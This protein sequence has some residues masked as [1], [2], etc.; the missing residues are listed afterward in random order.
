VISSGKARP[1]LS[2][3]VADADEIETALR[4]S[5]AHL[6]AL[7]AH[8]VDYAI[9]GLDADGTVSSWNSGAERL[10]G[11]IPQEALGQHFSIFFTEEDRGLG[12]PESVLARART[13]GHVQSIGKRVRRDGSTFW[14]DVVVTAIVADD[15]TVT[16]FVKVTRDLTEQRRLE[17]ARAALIATVTHDLKTPLTAISLFAEMVT[18]EERDVRAEYGRRIVARV[19]HVIKLVD[20]L[21]ERVQL[22]GDSTS[23]RLSPVLM[24]DAVARSVEN[25]A[26]IIGAGLV[27]VESTQLRALA[28]PVAAERV[29]TNLLSNAV[30]YSPDGSTVTVTF[31]EADGRACVHIADNGRGIAAQDLDTI[32]DEF[33]RGRLAQPDGGTGLGLASAKRLMELQGGSVRLASVVDG[34]TTAIADFAA[35]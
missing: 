19:E 18:D 6:R 7:V 34:G 10:K 11:Y 9:I 12:V 8:V 15:G 22:D 17:Q 1:P 30:K 29:L 16:G 20:S 21:V 13:D 3:G 4:L 24:G 14:G 33:I 23:I 35:I 26:G 31:T 32:F 25:L 27:V 2:G 5:E 28:D